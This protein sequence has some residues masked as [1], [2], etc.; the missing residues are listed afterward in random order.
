MEWLLAATIFSLSQPKDF[1]FAFVIRDRS[2]S[3]LS[4]DQAVLV[5]T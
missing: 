3:C 4:R 2:H 5:L 1:L